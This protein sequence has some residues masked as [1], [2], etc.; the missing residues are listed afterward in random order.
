[1][2]DREARD[3]SGL[4]R[5]IDQRYPNVGSFSGTDVM[6]LLAYLHD[7]VEAFD[8]R[9]VSEAAAVQLPGLWLTNRAKSVYD[10]LIRSGRSTIQ[11]RMRTT[12]A[13]V[14][15]AFLDKFITDDLLRDERKV[16]TDARQKE[17]E[18]VKGYARR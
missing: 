12:W 1:M 8:D 13:F 9:Q 11:S 5:A 4:K 3:L 16:V 14:V 18:S 6:A 2:S 17:N 15:H 10:S 7:L